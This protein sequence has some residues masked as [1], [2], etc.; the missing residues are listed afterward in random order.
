MHRIRRWLAT[1]SV[2]VGVLLTVAA[3]GSAPAAATAT[4]AEPVTIE[5][6][7]RHRSQTAHIDGQGSRAAGHHHRPGRR[8]TCTASGAAT[9]KFLIPYSALLYLPDG[10]T[11]AYTNPEGHA[12]VRETV[13]VE[14]IRGDQAVLT[15]GPPVGTAVV[16]AGAAELWGTEFGIK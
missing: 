4:A 1:G 5:A 2:I 7:R 12:Y 8:R 6:D 13:T 10:T 11:I 16:T 14:S 9:G 15:A 3:C